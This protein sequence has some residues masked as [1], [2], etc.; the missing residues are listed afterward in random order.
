MK[1][2]AKD[3]EVAKTLEFIGSKLDEVYGT[4]DEPLDLVAEDDYNTLD[5]LRE[6]FDELYSDFN[7]FF[8]EKV[9]Y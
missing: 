7:V 2:Y 8:E 5:D 9:G 4:F 6:R 1:K 3:S